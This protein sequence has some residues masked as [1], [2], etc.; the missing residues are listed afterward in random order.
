MDTMGEEAGLLQEGF[1]TVTQNQRKMPELQNTI[2]E[3]KRSL[4]EIES[5]MDTHQK[6][7]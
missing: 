1:E 6:N 2:S 5:R 3:I 4:D 7:Q